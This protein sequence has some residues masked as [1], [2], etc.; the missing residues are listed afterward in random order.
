[1]FVSPSLLHD[2]SHCRSSLSPPPPGRS[3]CPQPWSLARLS[4]LASR[5]LRALQLSPPNPSPPARL[6]KSLALAVPGARVQQASPLQPMRPTVSPCTRLL[7]LMVPACWQPQ[8]LYISVTPPVA[9]GAFSA[10]QSTTPAF[11]QMRDVGLF[12]SLTCAA[13]TALLPASS[14]PTPLSA[15]RQGAPLL[16]L[17]LIGYIFLGLSRSATSTG[18]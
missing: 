12:Q 7:P 5:Q 17:C 4:M 2:L 3:T 1:M 11:V 18:A 14:L 16:R 15:R 8:V 9:P 13:A 6:V 10:I